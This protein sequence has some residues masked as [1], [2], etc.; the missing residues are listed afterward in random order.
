[1]SFSRLSYNK[2]ESARRAAGNTSVL[3]SVLD[4]NRYENSNKCRVPLG[5]LGGNEV[6][7]NMDTHY[8]DI[9]SELRGLDKQTSKSIGIC[10][11]ECDSK[12]KHLPECNMFK[13]NKRPVSTGFIMPDMKYH[14]TRMF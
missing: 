5:I 13:S 7:I 6:S 11:Q 1:M 12:L 8:I 3:D 2:E 10:S 9:E 4:S 14:E